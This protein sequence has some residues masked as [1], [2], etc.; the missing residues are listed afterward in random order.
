MA[1]HRSF[2]N[3]L[4]Y[5]LPEG[6]KVRPFVTGGGHF[7]NHV[8]PGARVQFGEGDNKFGVNYGAGVKVR[9]TDRYLIRV[10][11]R[12]YLQGKPFGQFLATEQG[13]YR[14]TEIS[15]GFSFTL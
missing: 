14:G 6:I 13:S 10:D 5:M 15:L 11:V 4:V 2:Y 8:Q 3:F 7:A 9:V 1:I 12:Q